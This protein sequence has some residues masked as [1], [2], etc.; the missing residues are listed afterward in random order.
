[1]VAVTDCRP[2]ED[3]GGNLGYKLGDKI[4]VIEK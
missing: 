1:V 3:D 4:A 2:A